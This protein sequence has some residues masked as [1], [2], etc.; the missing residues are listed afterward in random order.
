MARV[1]EAAFVVVNPTRLAVA[2]AYRPPRVPV[3]AVL[4]R[5]RG[6]AAARVREIAAIY[7]IPIVENVALARTLY[8]DGCPGEAIPAAHYVV[9]AEVLA[10]LLRAGEIA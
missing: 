5:A 7:R 8:R 6:E 9:V 10:A 4:V 3:P 2:L 1:K